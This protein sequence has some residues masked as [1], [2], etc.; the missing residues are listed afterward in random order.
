MRHVLILAAPGVLLLASTSFGAAPAKYFDAA[1]PATPAPQRFGAL[2]EDVTK[3]F[4]ADVDGIKPGDL[5][6]G[7]NGNRVRDLT[8]AAFIHYSHDERTDAVVTLIRERNVT[9]LTLR[10]LFPNRRAFVKLHSAGPPVADLL[11]AW[12]ISLTEIFGM[13]PPT[14]SSEPAAGAVQD[15]LD[16]FDATGPVP[17]VL[18]FMAVEYL[19]AR[20]QDA[21]WSLA[22]CK[23]PADREWVLPFLQVFA[24]LVTG[25]YNE[26]DALIVKQHLLG[27]NI[28]PFLDRLAV[29]Y[30]AVAA[31]G[32]SPAKTLSPAA[33]GVDVPFFVLCYPYPV[34]ATHTTRSFDSDPE[35][36]VLFDKATSGLTVFTEE[37]R[38][39]A[40]R[41][42]NP[43]TNN[44]TEVYVG[45]VKAALLDG[46]NH[47]GW[48]FR[49]ALVYS[50]PNRG[51]VIAQLLARL[52]E[53]PDRT[54]ETALALLAP[55][56]MANNETAF[57]RA[58]T[59]LSAA[60]DREEACANDLIKST[61]RFWSAKPEALRRVR[62]TIDAGRPLPEFYQCLRK[63]SPTIERRLA[64][65]A[66]QRAG[67][68]VQDASYYCHSYP[69]VVARAFATPR[70]PEAVSRIEQVALLTGNAADIRE[71]LTVLT[72]DLASKPQLER[73]GTLLE[74]HDRVGAGPVCEAATRVLT[75]LAV[76]GDRFEPDGGQDAVQRMQSFFASVESLHYA[77]VA[78][79]LAAIENDDPA[80]DGTAED[81]YQEA[82]VPSVCLLLA[83]KLRDAG[84]TRQAERY[85]DKAIGLYVP[86]LEGY[87]TNDR[88]RMALRD[89]VSAPGFEAILDRYR[90]WMSN[91]STVAGHVLRAV[92]A[93]Y[94]GDTATVVREVLASTRPGGQRP[95]GT[96]LYNSTVFN[97]AEDLR[98]GLLRRLLARNALTEEQVAQL[99]AAP[100]L[101][102]DTIENVPAKPAAQR[103][104]P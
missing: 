50:E 69:A 88:Y 19:P 61:E 51:R 56:I 37:L 103:A 65:G 91:D 9:N 6:I 17:R 52:D 2:V 4:A 39:K 55:S 32:R 28:D 59:I 20:A 22:A 8:E 81:Y 12:N 46:D 27:R 101:Q 26:A 87:T 31:R 99:K 15:V 5:V 11:K 71:A 94:R 64:N 83:A 57:R 34:T 78:R 104:Q 74:L 7:I 45:Q 73:L 10:P 21:L 33:F 23:A 70:D 72:G 35:Y 54:V 97:S 24:R 66:C 25:R 102:F 98:A 79:E 62:Q 3:G 47:G 76:I 63:L 82:G 40:T 1:G 41:Y 29:F 100:R 92:G 44:D 75:Y 90:P 93:S 43:G 95:S 13:P 18:P 38:S 49:S 14:L 67:T 85:V 36:Q 80:L 89:F 30:Q 58:Y 48:P 53:K 60:G 77:R 84:H 86:L 68:F 96:Y 42:A 16:A